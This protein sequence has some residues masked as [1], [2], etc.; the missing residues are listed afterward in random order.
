MT[1]KG[2]ERH[3]AVLGVPMIFTRYLVTSPVIMIEIGYW[4]LELDR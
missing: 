2:T 1:L 3:S 4:E